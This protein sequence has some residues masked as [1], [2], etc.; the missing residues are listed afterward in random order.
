[1]APV[2]KTKSNEITSE[3]YREGKTITEGIPQSTDF[4]EI[5]AK[6]YPEGFNLENLLATLLNKNY[7]LLKGF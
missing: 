1:M 3:N 6:G 2:I 7:L 4:G 5:P